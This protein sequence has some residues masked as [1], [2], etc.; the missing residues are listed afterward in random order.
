[1]YGH[2]G[3]PDRSFAFCYDSSGHEWFAA[4]FLACR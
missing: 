4:I 2:C 1:L 3:F